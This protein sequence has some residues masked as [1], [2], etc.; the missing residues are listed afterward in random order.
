MEMAGEGYGLKMAQIKVL[1]FKFAPP[2]YFN[3]S[4]FLLPEPYLQDLLQD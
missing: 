2:K 1:L 4:W 3:T